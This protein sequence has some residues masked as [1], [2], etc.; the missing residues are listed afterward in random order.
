M[1]PFG[2]NDININR[3][4]RPVGSLNKTP[5]REKAVE[6]LNRIIEDLHTNYDLLTNE[7]KLKLLAVFKNLFEHSILIRESQ[8]PEEIKVNIIHNGGDTTF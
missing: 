5:N 1:C 8:L 4:G 3:F 6:L 7:E 2:K